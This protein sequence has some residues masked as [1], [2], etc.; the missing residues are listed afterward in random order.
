MPVSVGLLWGLPGGSVVKN[1]PAEAGDARGLGGLGRS[2]GEGKG[3][4][5]QFFCLGNSHGWR[6]LLDYSPWGH[7]EPGRTERPSSQAHGPPA[8]LGPC[9]MLWETPRLKVTIP[10]PQEIKYLKSY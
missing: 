7:K 8:G 4:P 3:N 6:S 1:P 9:Q 10:D 2:P 5:L